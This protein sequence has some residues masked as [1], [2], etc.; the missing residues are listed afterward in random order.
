MKKKKRAKAINF[1]ITYFLWN[2]HGA[3]YMEVIWDNRN[4]EI[5]L[6]LMN[7]LKNTSGIYSYLYLD[8]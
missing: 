4:K 1:G 8:F 2:F 3:C 6:K 5:Q 7:L